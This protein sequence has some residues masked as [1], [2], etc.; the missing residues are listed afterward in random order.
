MNKYFALI[1][2]LCLFALPAYAQLTPE[3]SLYELVFVEM[4]IDAVRTDISVNLGWNFENKEA[5]EKASLKAIEDLRG[6][7]NYLATMD[8]SG[9]FAGHKDLEMDIIDTLIQAYDDIDK[10]D[11]E[12]ANVLFEKADKLLEAF[13]QSSIETAGKFI[14][15]PSL[16]DTFN[17]AEE[18]I[19]SI[20]DEKDRQIYIN[21][22]NMIESKTV[23]LK[24]IYDA[25]LGL[26]ERYKGQVVED[27]IDLRISDCL[28]ITGS[29]A[30]SENEGVGGRELL[31]GIIARKRYSPVLFETFVKWRTIQQ[32]YD[33]G[34]S[35]W[36]TIP[37]QEYNKVRMELI[38]IIKDYLKTYPENQWARYQMLFL[39]NLDNIVRGYPMGNSNF[40]YM[41]QWYMNLSDK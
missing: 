32:E 25:L 29:D 37:N 39:L 20:N 19:K 9:E 36:S 40:L 10:K 34:M 35:N 33:H 14:I 16:P 12:E 11:P 13:R 18:E 15:S 7:K 21:A 28:L 26:K 5:M 17:N 1:I 24:D 6:L 3:D 22:Y 31:D 2:V 38:Q 27:C 23:K 8:L 4:Q 30:E 41:A